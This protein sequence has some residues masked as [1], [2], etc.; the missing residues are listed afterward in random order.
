MLKMKITVVEMKNLFD[1][2][3]RGLDTT[4]ES[5]SEL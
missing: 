1:G 2:I 5:V 3:I 4:K